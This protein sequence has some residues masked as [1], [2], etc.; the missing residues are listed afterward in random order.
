MQEIHLNEL[1][2]AIIVFK[3]EMWIRRPCLC[4]TH[5]RDKS[6]PYRGRYRE[7]L[8]NLGKIWDS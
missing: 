2:D 5:G 6:G 7:Q 1:M 8:T 4:S 3:N